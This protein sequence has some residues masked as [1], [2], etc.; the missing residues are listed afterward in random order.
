MILGALRRV[1]RGEGQRASA[2]Q[3]PDEDLACRVAERMQPSALSRVP[4]GDRSSDTFRKLAP[5][6]EG[7][8]DR[9][10]NAR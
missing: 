6:P 3:E 9:S 1:Q 10:T 4:G 7:R 2:A 5:L 8:P